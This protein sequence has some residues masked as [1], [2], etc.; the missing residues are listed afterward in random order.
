MGYISSLFKFL[1]LILVQNRVTEFKAN[2][3]DF[4][5]VKLGHK[6]IQKV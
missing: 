4:L 5:N 1:D 3:W 2:I 6:L